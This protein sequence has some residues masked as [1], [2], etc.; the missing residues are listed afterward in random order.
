MQSLLS[1]HPLNMRRSMWHHH[2]IMSPWKV[3]TYTY[4][5]PAYHGRNVH[6]PVL[7][8][9]TMVGRHMLLHIPSYRGRGC[10]CFCIYHPTM[11]GMHMPL[12]IPSYHGRDVHASELY[13][14]TLEGMYMHLHCTH[15]TWCGCTHSH[16]ICASLQPIM[17]AVQ[18]A[19]PAS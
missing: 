17:I 6:A 2:S 11:V 8:H 3:C 14:P 16:S 18:S 1:G 15:L 7:Y 10:T 13:P 5:V 19:V 9:P 4:T 12:H